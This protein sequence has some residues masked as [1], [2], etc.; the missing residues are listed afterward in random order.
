LK[1]SQVKALPRRWAVAGGVAEHAAQIDVPV[2]VGYGVVD[3]SPD[4]RAEAGLYRRSPDIASGD[5]YS[6][7]LR[8]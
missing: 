1:S 3:V 2:L 4:P 8:S 5:A 6:M 7:G